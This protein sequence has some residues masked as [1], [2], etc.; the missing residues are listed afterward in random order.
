MLLLSI[1]LN[2]FKFCPHQFVYTSRLPLNGLEIRGRHD[3]NTA[4]VKRVL[5]GYKMNEI[6]W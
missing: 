5:L 2:K 1:N 3:F 6:S 4:W